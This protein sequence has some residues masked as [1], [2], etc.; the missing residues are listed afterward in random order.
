ML[1][2]LEIGPRAEAPLEASA[3]AYDRDDWPHWIDADGDCQDTRQEVLVEESEVPVR[4]RDARRCAVAEGRWRCPYTGEVITDPRKLDVDH[5]VPLHEAHRSGADAW[6]R[7][8]RRRYANALDEPMHLIAVERGSN[9]A[10]GDKAP[11]LWMPESPEHR[12]DYVHAWIEVKDRWELK[13]SAPEQVYLD[14]AL[15]A[16]AGGKVPKLPR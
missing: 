10:K 13:Q 7:D 1:E 8:R 12:C 6:D 9:R 16:C 5:L 11:H 4:Y 14:Q 3:S 15:A 2:D